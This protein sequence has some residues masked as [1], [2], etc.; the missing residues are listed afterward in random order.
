[1]SPTLG[2]NQAQEGLRCGQSSITG[3]QGFTSAAGDP[4]RFYWVNKVTPLPV[5]P[6]VET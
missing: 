1:M 3:G 4:Q 5:I 6:V 2:S